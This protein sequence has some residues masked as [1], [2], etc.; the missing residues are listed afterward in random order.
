MTRRFFAARD[1]HPD[2]D[3]LA[4]FRRRF[5]GQFADVFVQVRQVARENPL[6][7][8][9]TVGLDGTRIH[10]NASRHSALSHV[11]AGKIE[12]RIKAEVQELLALAEEADRRDV[13]EGVEL[14]EKI[15]R[16]EDRLA[17]IAAAKAKIGVR[18]KERFEREQAEFEPGWPS[19][20]PGRRLL[21]KR[22]AASR[23]SPP[24]PAR[25]RKSRSS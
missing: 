5:G 19:V 21:A 14:P 23:S 4:T 10:A 9:G 15:K 2:C 6:S 1:P 17:A 8:F 25:A 13:P 22:L 18:A 3:T 7:C 20:R 12:A 16:R 11:H 24:K